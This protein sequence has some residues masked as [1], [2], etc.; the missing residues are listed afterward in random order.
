MSKKIIKKIPMY[1]MSD[2]NELDYTEYDAEYLEFLKWDADR[3]RILN[4]FEKMYSKYYINMSEN[5]PK[6]DGKFIWG[7]TE[8]LKSLIA[9][10]TKKE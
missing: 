3:T 1:H 6:I 4:E 9:E 8:L 10:I 2:E 5:E 7:K